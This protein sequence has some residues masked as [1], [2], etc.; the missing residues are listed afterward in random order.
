VCGLRHELDGSTPYE[1]LEAPELPLHSIQTMHLHSHV[2]HHG[3]SDEKVGTVMGETIYQVELCSRHHHCHVVRLRDLVDVVQ[4]VQLLN[5]LVVAL[6][7]LV[8]RLVP[9]QN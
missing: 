7:V 5:V 2:Q 6:H 1:R 8:R 9:L 4:Q 3:C